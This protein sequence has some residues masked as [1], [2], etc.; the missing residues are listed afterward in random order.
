MGK[1]LNCG[2]SSS[3]ISDVIGVCVNCLRKGIRS[4]RDLHLES[5]TL[6]KL[7]I[8]IEQAEGIHCSVCG[9]G[10]ILRNER[11]GYCNY[12]MESKGIIKPS[13]GMN[14]D[15]IGFYYYD[16]HPT[17][18]VAS[19]VCPAA[20]GRGYPEYA[21]ST[22]G[23]YGYYNIAVFYGGCNLDCLYCQ[24]WEYREMAR[25][26]NPRLSVDALV[27]AVS[28][29]TTC[30]CYF[31]GD[32]GPFA[33]HALLAS[34]KMRSKAKSIGLKVFRICWETNG[35]WNPSLLEEATKISLISGG[36]VKIDFKAWSPEVYKVLC[37]IEE[38]H[39][40]I[41]R[42][43]IK[44]VSKYMQKRKE[45]PLLVISTLLVPG[46]IDEYEID[47]MTKFIAELN[48]EIPYVFLGFHPDYI[49]TD[50]PTTSR[51]H[52]EKAVK[53]ARE[54]GLK[55]VYIENIFLL[56]DAY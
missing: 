4:T 13:T 37:D 54:N 6:F 49:L 14:F 27:N 26:S 2:I 33:P 29:K 48:S 18:C 32:P 44:L 35:L 16:P 39:V 40:N 36:I 9:R 38:K 56:G 30:V 23:E 45:P 5:R 52:A 11:K 1:C 47:Q 34:K 10:C 51:K 20:T 8:Y 55:H 22:K 17:N 31:G 41:I 46:Y 53:I 12:R 42:N 28:E 15:A 21:L 50:L 24:N 3:T 19:P 7:P 25:N 43:N